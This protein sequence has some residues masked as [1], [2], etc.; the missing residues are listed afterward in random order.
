MEQ[1]IL[2]NGYYIFKN[3]W[4]K[5][6]DSIR[7]KILE[8]KLEFRICYQSSKRNEYNGLATKK[9]GGGG[10]NYTEKGIRNII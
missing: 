4:G 3:Y 10:G 5:T 8:K 1:Q 7:N 2:S 6:Q 9:K